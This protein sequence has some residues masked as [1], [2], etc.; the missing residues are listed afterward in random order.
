MNF[1]KFEWC[2]PSVLFVGMMIDRQGIRPA[3]SNVAAMAELPP[4]STVKE[5]IAHLSMTGYLRQFVEQYSILAVI[6][7]DIL[8]N[9]DFASKRGRWYPIAWAEQRKRA[10]L[11]LKSALT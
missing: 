4:P 3:E 5:T 7:T 2:Y 8:P 10:F 9:N 1:V 6:F 11:A